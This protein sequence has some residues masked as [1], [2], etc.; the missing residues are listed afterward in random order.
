MI[1]LIFTC[2]LSDNSQKKKDERYERYIE[3][4]T[5]TLEL[6]HEKGLEQKDFMRGTIPK[7]FA[8]I[9]EKSVNFLPNPQVTRTPIFTPL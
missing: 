3:C 5:S 6:I 1:Y 4:I 8:D 7:F 2:S 9:K